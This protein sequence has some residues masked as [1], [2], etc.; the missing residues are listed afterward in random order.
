MA[1]KFK[2]NINKNNWFSSTH[3]PDIDNYWCE[4]V[5]TVKADKAVWPFICFGYYYYP[6][7]T[8]LILTPPPPPK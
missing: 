5:I 6:K 3:S 8:G 7:N 2:K 4:A 1:S